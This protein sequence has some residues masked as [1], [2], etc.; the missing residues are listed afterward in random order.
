MSLH[1]DNGEPASDG[2][3]GDGGEFDAARERIVVKDGNEMGSAL[4]FIFALAPVTSI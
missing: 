2:E 3:E 4:R 1:R